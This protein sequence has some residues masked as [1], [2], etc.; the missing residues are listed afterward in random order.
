MQS[1]RHQ[2]LEEINQS[3]AVPDV[4]QTAFGANF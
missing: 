1:H 2:S 3:V 4:H